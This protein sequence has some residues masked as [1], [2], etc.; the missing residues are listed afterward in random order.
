ML[1]TQKLCY[2]QVHTQELGGEGG[3]QAAAPSKS[4]LKKHKLCR[5]DDIKMFYMI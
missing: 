2:V 3:C 1:M 5:Y 4:T